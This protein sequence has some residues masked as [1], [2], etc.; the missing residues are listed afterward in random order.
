MQSQGG[1]L[2][3]GSFIGQSSVG[4]ALQWNGGRAAI[5]IS[6]L[7]YQASPGLQLQI[8]APSSNAGASGGNWVNIASSFVADQMFTFDA[9]RGNYR[10]ANNSA[11]SVI[12]VNAA[13]VTV[14]Y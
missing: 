7:V 11:S 4:T 13:M 1:I 9:P 14:Q 8:Q 2:A 3:G 12:G 5:V 6:A 10:L